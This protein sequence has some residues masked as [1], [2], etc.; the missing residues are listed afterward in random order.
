MTELMES[1]VIRG[2]MS[3]KSDA[4]IQSLSA[5]GSYNSRL[6]SQHSMQRGTSGLE[7]FRNDLQ[8]IGMLGEFVSSSYCG[9]ESREND[10]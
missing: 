1:S 2:A 3:V 7:Y 10:G 5:V 9:I 4:D 8:S 6:N